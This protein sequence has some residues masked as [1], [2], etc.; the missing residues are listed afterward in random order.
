MKERIEELTEKL[1]QWNRAYYEQ[2]RPVVTDAVYD[3]AMKELEALEA[4]YPQYK[5]SDSPT[6]RVGGR[7][8]EGFETVEH[9]LPLLS[10]SN[11]FSAGELRDFHERLIKDGVD[12][13]D[14]IVEWKIDG[15]TVALEYENGFFVRGATRGDGKVGEDITENLNTVKTVPLS[16]PF[17]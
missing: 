10:L 6:L 3:R 17:S 4:Q 15:L 2:D 9:P 11:T 12:H 16:I 5:R 14:Y 13:P 1:N 8:V 7:P